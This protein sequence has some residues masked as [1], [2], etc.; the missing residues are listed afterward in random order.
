M[1]KTIHV[2]VCFLF[3]TLSLS[4]WAQEMELNIGGYKQY[5]GDDA[6]TVTGKVV[7]E[8]T[9]KKHQKIIRLRA[10]RLQW[11]NDSRIGKL[12]GDGSFTFKDLK[13]GVYYLASED[14]E[15]FPVIAESGTTDVGEFVFGKDVFHT[16]GTV[17]YNGVAMKGGKV[18]AMPLEADRSRC[19]WPAPVVESEIMEDGSYD[20]RLIEQ[21]MYSIK[22]WSDTKRSPGV[23]RI[24][25]LF[26]NL[27]PSDKPVDLHCPVTSLRVKADTQG[28][29]L[30]VGQH[31]LVPI[32]RHLP[33]FPAPQHVSHWLEYKNGHYQLDHIPNDKFDFLMLRDPFANGP[34]RI[35]AQWLQN[36]DLQAGKNEVRFPVE[37][38]AT[39]DIRVDASFDKPTALNILAIVEGNPRLSWSSRLFINSKDRKRSEQTTMMLRKGRYIFMVGPYQPYCTIDS[40]PLDLTGDIT[41]TAHMHEAGQVRVQLAGENIAGRTVRIFDAL[42]EEVYRLMVPEMGESARWHEFL[43]LPTDPLGLTDIY[44]L[45]PGEYTLRVDGNEVETPVEVKAGETTTVVVELEK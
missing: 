5:R 15:A 21:G 39:V 8:N 41:L 42:D 36:V 34:D 43:I 38:A 10:K 9:P 33:G 20:L 29:N 14:T 25:E 26:E 40:G 27:E 12:K 35:G 31:R 30:P 24:F 32:S 44:C 37:D 23:P 11:P 3:L 45:A 4:L 16:T 2:V 6:S 13:P 7:F 22:V 1:M 19:I 18:E 28:K 17:Y